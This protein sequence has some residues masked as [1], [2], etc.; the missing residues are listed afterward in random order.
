VRALRQLK[1][2][3]GRASRF[4]IHPDQGPL[5][6]RLKREIAVLDDGYLVALGNRTAPAKRRWDEDAQHDQ[7]ARQDSCPAGGRVSGRRN[8]GPVEPGSRVAVEDV[9]G[10]AGVVG[11]EPCSSFLS[12]SGQRAA[13]RGSPRESPVEGGG[14]G[15]GE[16]ASDFPPGSDVRTRPA[17]QKGAH[18]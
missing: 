4:S 14:E 1:G 12:R 17:L 7:N 13:D 10:P 15:G 11:T 18:Q 3:R 2:Q 9:A 5:G 16:G 8:A 6:L